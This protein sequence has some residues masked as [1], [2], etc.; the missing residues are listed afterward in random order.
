[1]NPT[2]LVNVRVKHIRPQY[3]NLKEWMNYSNNVYIG[4]PRIVFIDGVRFPEEGSIW[5]NPFK[6]EDF[7]NSS[8]CG[9][10]NYL[11]LYE[12]HARKLIEDGNML[13]ELLKLKGK[14]LGCWCHPEP[15]HGEILIKLI[16]EITT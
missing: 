5:A 10:D 7:P 8:N 1:M 3:Q 2:T 9:P 6:V 14:V 4:R 12:K 13:D 15:C 11:E 16:N